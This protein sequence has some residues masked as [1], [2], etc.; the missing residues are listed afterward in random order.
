[1]SGVDLIALAERVEAATGPDRELD[2]AIY[3][4]ANPK[5]RLFKGDRPLK[6]KRVWPTTN[7]LDR[8]FWYE[9][10]SGCSGGVDD[11]PYT[12]SLDAAMT[13]V[14]PGWEA[15]LNT[16]A[17]PAKASAYCINERNDIVRPA[18]QYLA[19]AALALTAAALRAR[20]AA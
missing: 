8:V 1:V 20:A 19:T 12:G 18:K 5:I 2:A 13:L 11:V 9:T 14:P 15:S 16:F 3:L 6:L 7:G 4:L 10:V 17:N